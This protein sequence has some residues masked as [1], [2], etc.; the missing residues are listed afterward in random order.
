LPTASVAIVPEVAT[1]PASVTGVPKLLPSIANCTV[2]LGVPF[3]GA[4]AVT[5]AV[6][7]TVCP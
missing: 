2:P 1:L 6:K 5:L 4:S 7:L 3:P